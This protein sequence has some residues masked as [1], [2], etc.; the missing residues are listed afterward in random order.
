MESTPKKEKKFK[1]DWEKGY[2]T[3]TPLEN[4][5]KVVIW[6]AEKAY[7]PKVKADH[8]ELDYLAVTYAHLSVSC[9]TPSQVPHVS[10]SGVGLSV[11]RVHQVQ[12]AGLLFSCAK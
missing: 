2:S 10:L 4:D 1:Y 7:D 6:D 3:K 9:G 5:Y 12:P 11:Q 8:L